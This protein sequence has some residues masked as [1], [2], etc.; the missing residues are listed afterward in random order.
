MNSETF[1]SIAV[2]E[3]SCQLDCILIFIIAVCVFITFIHLDNVNGY[4]YTLSLF[5]VQEMCLVYTS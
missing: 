2:S 5:Q 3:K 1:T 4:V